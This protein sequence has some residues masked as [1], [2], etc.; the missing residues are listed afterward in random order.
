SNTPRRAPA[1]KVSRG[2]V[3]PAP[4]QTRPLSDMRVAVEH[5]PLTAA[6][7]LAAG[8]LIDARVLVISADG[9]DSELGAIEQTL[10]Y[11]GTPFD[12]MIANQAPALSASQLASGTH[13]KYNAIIL[14]RGNLVLPDGTSA[15]TNDEF[16]TL[17]SYESAFEVRRVSLYTSPD[18]GYG[19]SGSMTQ[20]TST[21]PLTVQC[22][23]AA[24]SV[25]PY[26]NCSAGV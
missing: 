4:G 22:T 7:P 10:G 20:D 1:V 12:V 13:G 18:A 8:T 25:F 24:R 3:Q 16:Q 23:T 17:A 9:T 14:T 15:F 21:T 2:P 6:A 5:S 19:Y 11:L 26:V